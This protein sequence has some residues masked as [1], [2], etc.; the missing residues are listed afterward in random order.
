M[1]RAWKFGDNI[2]TDVITPAE[3]LH[4]G[5]DEGG[6]P[7]WLDHALEPIR[8]EF[9]G[10]V[11][12]GDV[13]V[14]GKNFGAGSSREAAARVFVMKE[15]EAV[16]A[17]EFARIWFRN[18]I[19]VGLPVYR[20]AAAS[21][22]IDDGDEVRIDHATSTIVNETTGESYSADPLPEFVQEIRDAGG[23]AKYYHTKVK[24]E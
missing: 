10:S 16:V 11:E 7:A 21:E 17:A 9:A 8:P 20:S 19:N 23:L 1:G 24:N 6:R 13:V 2:D 18:A 22:G 15:V 14:A 4:Q 3:Y 5:E 12:E